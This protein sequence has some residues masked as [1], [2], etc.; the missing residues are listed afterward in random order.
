MAT[1][2]V[3][4]SIA[5]PEISVPITMVLRKAVKVAK[6]G[7]GGKQVGEVKMLVERMEEG[8]KWIEE[9]RRRV[10]FAPADGDQVKRWESD[11]KAKLDES[12]IGKTVRVLRKAREKRRKLLEKARE[13]EDEI[14]ET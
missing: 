12:P 2:Q 11:L 14:L 4:G 1:P 7:K 3:Q 10:T 8:A 9:K 5:F 13:G 6:E